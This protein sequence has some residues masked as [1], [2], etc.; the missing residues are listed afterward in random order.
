V[1]L[2]DD[3]YVAQVEA[4]IAHWRARHAAWTAAIERIQVDPVHDAVAARFDSNGTLIA[5]DIDPA[6]LSNYTNTEL[7]QIITE[8]L[9]RTRAS[10][11]EQVMD[12]FA[13]YLAPND[14]RF[15]PGALGGAYVELPT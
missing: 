14:P 12:L 11:H 6:A 2:T 1:A 13:T 3:E 9:Q 15:D 5:V 8:V 10:V 7:E 4:T